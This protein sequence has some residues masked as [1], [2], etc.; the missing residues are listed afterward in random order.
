MTNLKVL[1]EVGT[2]KRMKRVRT[3]SRSQ[4]MRGMI[5]KGFPQNTPS[6]GLGSVVMTKGPTRRVIAARGR[7]PYP[8]DFT[9]PRRFRCCQC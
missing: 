5:T 1:T 9:R 7:N 2:E 8:Y 3:L 6:T 4:M